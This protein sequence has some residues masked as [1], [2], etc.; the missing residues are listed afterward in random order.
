MGDSITAYFLCFMAKIIA[1]ECFAPDRF[2]THR[3]DRDRTGKSSG[4]YQ[5]FL[6]IIDYRKL[7]GWV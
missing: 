5:R 4:V 6:R 2:G 3:Q 1:L 7:S